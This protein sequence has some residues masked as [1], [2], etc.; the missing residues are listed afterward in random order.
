MNNP[1]V[2]QI[3]RIP[4]TEVFPRVEDGTWAAKAVVDE[5][6]PVRATV[7]RE[8]HDQ[9]GV[10]ALLLDPNG[11]VVQRRKMIDIAPGLDR[12][13]AWLVPPTTG[14]YSFQI[15]SYSDPY[16]TW[17]HDAAA[18]IHA[19]IDTELVFAQGVELFNRALNRE[20]FPPLAAA[21]IESDPALPAESV[22]VLKEAIKLMQDRKLSPQERLSAGLA[23][24]SR[25]IFE[26]HPLRD[27]CSRTKPLPIYVDRQRALYGS[28]YEVFPRS[29]GA[30]QN[31]DGTWTS[32]NFRGL[33]KDLDRI[34]Q[35]GFDVLYLTPVHP[36]GTAFRKGKNN[37]L[38]AGPNDP[39]SPY[40]IGSP[41]GGHDE[42]HPDLGTWEDFDHLVSAAAEHGMEMA[43][44]LALQCSPDHPWVKEHPEWFSKRPDGS[45]AYAENPPK[46]YQDIYPLNFDQDPEGIFKAIWDVVTKWI[47]HG[48]KIFRV[49]NPHT[50][51]LSFWQPFLAKM[52]QQHPEVLFLAEAFTRPAMMRTLGMVGFHQ[53]YTYFTW[54][55]SK[56]ELGEYFTEVSHQTDHLMRPAFWPTTHDILTPTMTNGGRGAFALRAVLAATGSPTWGIYSGYELV[57]SEPRPGF[58]EQNNNEKY[59]YRPRDWEAGKEFGIARLLTKLNA[60]R[61]Q[62]PAL[63]QL[64]GYQTLD[65]TS[66]EVFAFIKYIRKENSP[67]G[68]ADAVIVIVNLDPHNPRE[69]SVKVDT[70]L[71]GVDLHYGRYQVRDLLDDQVY[72]WGT[73]NYVYLNPVDRPAHVFAVESL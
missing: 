45:I 16:A 35:M 70:S 38:T 71:L 49:D 72:Q 8:G 20:T 51:P 62:H 57:E 6:F 41:E 1:A 22:K 47:N 28:W 39:G 15:E 67:T 5:A 24:G 26:A 52:R 23:S 30:T 33:E 2:L 56:A 58:E 66:D 53:S 10:A 50:K 4:V 13:E 64:R 25:R 73:D 37:T 40:G 48:V 12:Y 65:T 7:F 3:N 18:K 68:K 19:G 31:A 55:N 29:Y 11:T 14:A 46:K 54:R 17:C 42:I 59:E 44:D 43:L 36:I 32:G 34:S 21:G 60:A 61:A 63:Q 27:L 9:L 69:A